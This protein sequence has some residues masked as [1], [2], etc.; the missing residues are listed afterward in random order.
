MSKIPSVDPNSDPMRFAPEGFFPGYTWAENDTPGTLAI[1]DSG[2]T[3]DSDGNWYMVRK[4]RSE[5]GL[6]TIQPDDLYNAPAE[7]HWNS[8]EGSGLYFTNYTQAAENLPIG[9]RPKDEPRELY[10]CR[11]KPDPDAVLDVTK[12][13]RNRSLGQQAAAILLRVRS[14]MPGV[15]S[16]T[17][18]VYDKMYADAEVVVTPPLAIARVFAG[19]PFRFEDGTK[20]QPRWAIVRDTSLV[21][22]VAHKHIF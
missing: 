2:F 5:V 16:P 6:D 17:R 11:V 1:N 13:L 19:S 3:E 4:A 18:A 8:T 12:S 7:R 9:V 15:P 22:P 20:L 14:V 21:I 10:V